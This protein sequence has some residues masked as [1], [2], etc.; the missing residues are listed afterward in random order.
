MNIF[1]AFSYLFNTRKININSS[2]SIRNFALSVGEPGKS[3]DLTSNLPGSSRAVN[4]DPLFRIMSGAPAITQPLYGSNLK[5]ELNG[6]TGTSKTGGLFAVNCYSLISGSGHTVDKNVG[7]SVLGDCGSN[8]A[9]TTVTENTS[10]EVFGIASRGS[11]TITNARSQTIYP[12]NHGANRRGLF[13]AAEGTTGLAVGDLN[14]S[15]ENRGRS[16][17]G[18]EAIFEQGVVSSSLNPRSRVGTNLQGDNLVL[19]PGLGTGNAVHAKI[20]FRGFPG[21]GSNSSGTGSHI[22][23]EIAAFIRE[24]FILA[25]FT[26]GGITSAEDDGVSLFQVNG[27]SRFR[28]Y[29]LQQIVLTADTNIG[30][31]TTSR[32]SGLI[33]V[34][35]TSGNI[36]IST[37]AVN[38]LTKN[39]VYIIKIIAGANNVI[40]SP[41]TLID[42]AATLTLSGINSKV[43]ITNDGTNW[44]TI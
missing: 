24:R 2:D 1:R 22:A 12:P 37:I 13:I 36:T 11:T 4:V 28:N 35:T 17:F 15:F 25:G 41:T 7:L 39:R 18:N 42:G 9:G 21:S 3:Y 19:T 26:L 34:D 5:V 31:I 6:T 44:Y 20:S 43:T 29:A 23:S 32:E 8:L 10:L 16:I 33:F 14:T 40:F 38:A 27:T 30:L